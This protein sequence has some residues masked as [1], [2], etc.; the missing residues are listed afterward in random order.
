M[1]VLINVSILFL[2]FFIMTRCEKDEEESAPAVKTLTAEVPES[3]G[4]I[5]HGE[6]RGTSSIDSYGFYYSYDSLFS[7]YL[8]GI[9]S[10]D[11]PNKSGEFQA[12]INTGLRIATVYFYK[13]FIQTNGNI[14]FGKTSLFLSTG[15]KPPQILQVIPE[16]GHIEDTVKIYGKDFGNNS[17]TNYTEVL[18]SGKYARIIQQSDSLITCV[19]PETN[20]LYQPQIK[21]TIFNKSDSVSFKLYTPIIESFSPAY[22]TFRDT[23]SIIGQHFDINKTRNKVQIGSVVAEIVAS[24]RNTLKI[25]IPDN[26]DKSNARINLTAQ[27][28]N[29]ISESRFKL[30]APEIS[31]IP[32][33]CYSYSEIEVEGKHFHPISYKNKVFI[34]GVESQVLSGDTESLTIKV[35][36]GP[37]PSGYASVKIL[38]ADTAVLSDSEFCIQDNWLMISNSLPFNFYG[39]IGTFT[40]GNFA[41]VISNSCDNA[42]D[43]EYLWKFNPED[44]SWQKYTIPFDLYY[45]GVCAS[46][47]EKGYVYTADKEDNFWEFDPLSHTWTKKANFPGERRDKAASFSVNQNIFVGIGSDFNVTGGKAFHDFY[48]YDPFLDIWSKISD[49]NPDE[50]SARTGAST[51]VIGNTAYLSG[52]ANSTGMYDAWKYIPS[53]DQWI[54]I[55]DFPDARS[56]T[57]SFILNGKGYI[58]N[59]TPV[60]SMQTKECWEYDPV[61]N[62]WKLFYDIGHRRRDDGFAFSVNG[63]A[64]VGGGSGGAND[65]T[66][67]LELFRLRK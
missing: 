26:L 9:I 33:C 55:A 66:T 25:I 43:Q 65:G 24:S 45:S 41:Y 52:G 37:Y 58:A 3:G 28:Q 44:Y 1:R 23:I 11:K 17:F 4:V 61:T 13:A 15:S 6:L 42:D 19:I 32:E 30:I 49:L 62:K 36:M 34:E 60:G 12:E 67:N 59:G 40:I 35:P 27:L 54:R 31:K 53:T 8:T 29:T 21:V 47:G 39:D 38:V 22:G 63:I 16:I 7:K 48:K 2:S 20:K 5:L 18:F 46:N 50:Y 64:F 51:F 56:S 57:S 10:F 14:L